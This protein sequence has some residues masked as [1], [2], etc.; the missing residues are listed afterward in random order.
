MT[1]NAKLPKRIQPI[2]QKTV[3][4]IVEMACV[5]ARKR[6]AVVPWIVEVHPFAATELV[7]AQG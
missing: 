7:I 6:S 3:A 1:E 5:M 2:V 4:L